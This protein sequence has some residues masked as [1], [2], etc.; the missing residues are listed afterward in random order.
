MAPARIRARH[1]KDGRQTF[2][3]GWIERRYDT[4]PWGLVA[5]AAEKLGD[6]A[7]AAC[8][9]Q[10]SDSLRGSS[11]WNVLEEAAWQSLRARF[12]Q[13]QWLDPQVCTASWRNH[14]NQL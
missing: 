6:A 12:S 8:W 2:G 9:T 5:L 13:P 10:Q 1:G 14:E 4:H 11:S 3:A 7:S